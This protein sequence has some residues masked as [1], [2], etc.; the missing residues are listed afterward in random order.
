[1]DVPCPRYNSTDFQ[2][3]SLVGEGL[4]YPPDTRAQF[5]GFLVGRGG[6]GVPVRASTTIET[7]QTTLTTQRRGVGTCR[8]CRNTSVHLSN[9]EAFV[10]EISLETAA[11]KSLF[12]AR[13]QYRVAG[14]VFRAE[15]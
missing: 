5:H 10:V 6:P 4:L 15:S 8:I 12:A 11:S 3:V 7:R 9:F 1:M 14:S 13:Q 2:K